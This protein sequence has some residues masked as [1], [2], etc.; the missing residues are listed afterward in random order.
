[1]MLWT[2]ANGWDTSRDGSIRTPI[3][4]M[5]A[6]DPEIRG[7]GVRSNNFQTI[8]PPTASLTASLR[9]TF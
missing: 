1:M 3:A 9:L 6:W 8:M 4:N 7:S 2:E 5:I